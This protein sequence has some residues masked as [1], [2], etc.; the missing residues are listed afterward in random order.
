VFAPPNA[1]GSSRTNSG[2]N[3]L[4]HCL[5]C[6]AARLVP[7]ATRCGTLSIDGRLSSTVSINLGVRN[8][9]RSFVR[10]YYLPFYSAV[11]LAVRIPAFFG[12]VRAKSSISHA[13][14]VQVNPPDPESNED[15]CNNFRYRSHIFPQRAVR[16]QVLSGFPAP[17]APILPVASG[18]TPRFPRTRSAFHTGTSVSKAP[19]TKSPIWQERNQYR[20]H[21]ALPQDAHSDERE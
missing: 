9:F 1:P 4:R 18:A 7:V 15:V 12:M 13:Q 8:R 21:K 2:V 11:F 10:S 17:P 5:Q 14:E 20:Q 6:T 16:Y 3:N 19:S